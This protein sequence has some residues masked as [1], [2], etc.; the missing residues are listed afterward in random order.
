MEAGIT[1][2]QS[3]RRDWERLSLGEKLQL[4]TRG[5]NQKGRK[6]RCKQN[7]TRKETL[8][9]TGGLTQHQR[10]AR[11]IG[12]L[13]AP[14]QK[15]KL[16]GSSV[17]LKRHDEPKS[18]SGLSHNQIRQP[19]TRPHPAPHSRGGARG[20]LNAMKLIRT[21]KTEIHYNG[22]LCLRNLR[23]FITSPYLPTWAEKAGEGK[24]L[25]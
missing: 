2:G 4:T 14:S 6:L 20:P 25:V 17:N 16:R 1:H 11:K 7:P 12:A 3:Q 18:T 5:L 13:P 23:G 22:P 15:G 24:K 9:A 10:G 21:I 19:T 8:R